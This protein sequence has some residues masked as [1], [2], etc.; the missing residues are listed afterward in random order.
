[1]NPATLV[2]FLGLALA[3]MIFAIIAVK[4]DEKRPATKR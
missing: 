4:G 2:L 3:G 1:M